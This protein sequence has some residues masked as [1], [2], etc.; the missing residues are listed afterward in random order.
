MEDRKMVHTLHHGSEDHVSNEKG[1]EGQHPAFCLF[2]EGNFFDIHL[3]E[4]LSDL[5]MESKWR[6]NNIRSLKIRLSFVT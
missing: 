5:K 3:P 6:R 4:N 1:K 2:L